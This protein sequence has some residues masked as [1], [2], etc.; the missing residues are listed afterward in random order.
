MPE[1]RPTRSGG[2]KAYV[3]GTRISVENI[4]VCHELHELSPDHILSSYPHLNLP[5]I[6]AALAYHYEHASEIRDQLK[7]DEDFAGNLAA[8]Q[9]PT[10]FTK[11]QDEFRNGG[12]VDD[13]P[14]SP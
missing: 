9:G 2:E 14:L 5:Q 11:L 6:H 13:D 8:E 1:L 3:A 12:D 10:R 4:Y 7:Q